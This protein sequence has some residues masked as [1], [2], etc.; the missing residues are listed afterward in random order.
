MPWVLAHMDDVKSARLAGE[1]FTM[2]TGIVIEREL[3]TKV[4]TGFRAGPSDDPAEG[5][6][7]LDP[8]RDR[9][10]PA[11]AALA[12]AFRARGGE[13]RRGARY[14]L[15]Q[16]I[17]DGSTMRVLREGRLRERAAAAIERSLLV[18]GRPL[19]EVRAPAFRQK[20]A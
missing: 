1:A 20:P 17:T 4:P 5:D 10:W 2:I 8:D 15:G 16:P 9:P 6:V 19:F 18:P 13:L 3:A 11:P 14:L 7:A 12:A